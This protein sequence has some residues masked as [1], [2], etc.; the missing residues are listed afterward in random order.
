MPQDLK[1]WLAAMPPESEVDGRI[2]EVENE[3]ELL[4]AIK[5]VRAHTM[6][7]SA[8]AGPT[9]AQNGALPPEVE[10]LR[11]RLSEQRLRILD[12]IR[13]QRNGRATIPEVVSAVDPNDRA[14]IASNMQRMVKARLL[15]RAGRGRYGL[16]PGAKQLI[17]SMDV[18][19]A[20][21][22]SGST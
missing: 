15:S 8:K 12:A 22:G 6:E 3:L 7:G 19:G 11:S 21:N 10:A 17:Q 13:S 16:T 4:R 20:T 5:Q 14:N 1:A 18:D 9:E 2:S